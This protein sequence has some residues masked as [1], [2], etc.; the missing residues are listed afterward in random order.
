MA[1]NWTAAENAIRSWFV[2]GSGLPD[3]SVVWADQA[4]PQPG[5]PYAT[6]K[7][8]SAVRVGALDETTDATN[9][10]GNGQPV[11]VTTTVQGVREIHV[12]CQVFA[13]P[14]TG[15]GTAREYLLSAQTALELPNVRYS[16][17][18]AGLSGPDAGA[19]SDISALLETQFQARAAMDVRF[20]VVDTAAETNG[21]I[22]TVNTNATVNT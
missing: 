10:D 18:T 6:L 2:A 17:L 8:T 11:S 9:L 14:V 12:S 21:F 20:Y 16:F 1:F 4:M 5:T 19:I 7:I 22:E 15:S 13:A 3:G